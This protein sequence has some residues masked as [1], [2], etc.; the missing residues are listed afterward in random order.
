MYRAIIVGALILS[1]VAAC[2]RES[3]RIENQSNETLSPDDVAPTAA[4]PARNPLRDAYFGETHLHTTYSL[5]AYMGMSRNGPDEAYR[6]AKGEAMP[7]PGGTARISAPLDFAAVTDHAE[8]LSDVYIATHPDNPRY[9]EE[10]AIKIRNQHNSEEVGEWVFV[11]VV[12]KATRSGQATELSR[13]PEGKVARAGAWKEIQEATE[14][15]NDPGVFTTFHA[16][17]WS[18]APQGFNLHRNI[19]FRDAVLPDIPVSAL[20]TN[21]P[22]KLWEYLAAYEKAGSTLLAIPHNANYS[23]DLMFRAK[24]LTGGSIGIDWA[25]TRA[26]FEPLVEMMQIKQN[27][28]TNPAYAPNDEFAAFESFPIDSKRQQGRHNWVREA[29]KDGLRLDKEFG[30]NPFKIG[31]V[32]G[33][34]SHNGTPSDVEENDWAGSHGFA[35]GSPK[36]RLEDKLQG[37][38]TI[39]RLNPGG[40]TGVWAEENTRAAIFDAMARKETFVTSGP[41]IRARLFAGWDY[42]DDLNARADML[43]K[44]YGGGVPMGG[45]LSQAPKGKSPKLLVTAVKGPRGA[46]LDRIQVVKG[47]LDADGKVHEKIFDVAWSSG[48]TQDSKGKLPAVGNTVDVSKASYTNSIG[49]PSLS[50]VWSDHEFNPEWRAFYYARVLEIPTPRWSTHD[51]AAVG[52]APPKDVPASIQERAWTSPIWYTP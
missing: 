22:E 17:E 6:F 35:D 48:R 34:D 28:E 10:A 8:F 29:L 45:D 30:A 52:I 14:R 23:G 7:V 24:T 40:I 38:E 20:D 15:H 46:N 50:G 42:P 21:E 18:S 36:K 2:D 19:I 3:S 31:F 1:I 13:G 43:S 47:W 11:N 16:F 37:W 9:S 32:G 25:R 49:D 5:D 39:R 51:A 27:S 12:Q 33:T 44:A 41:R 4:A 26:R